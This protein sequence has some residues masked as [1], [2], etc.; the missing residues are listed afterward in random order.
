MSLNN[1]EIITIFNDPTHILRQTSQPV[2]L[3][4]DTKTYKIIGKIICTL[5]TRP[6]CVSITAR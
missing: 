2:H 1:C 6:E 4:L 3:P 5:R